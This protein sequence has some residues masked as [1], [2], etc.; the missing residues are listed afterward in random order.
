VSA[1][2]SVLISRQTVAEITT[3]AHAAELWPTFANRVVLLQGLLAQSTGALDRAVECYRSARTLELGDDGK[4]GPVHLLA[5]LAYV[6]ARV[7]Q[8]V[9][10][11]QHDL[12]SL[13]PIDDPQRILASIVTNGDES[14][15][16][17]VMLALAAVDASN[18]SLPAV[19]VIGSILEAVTGSGI[20]KAKC[21]VALGHRHADRR[22]YSL[23]AALNLVTASANAYARCAIL[24]LLGNLFVHV[25]SDQASKMLVNAFDLARLMGAAAPGLPSPELVAPGQ[26]PLPSSVVGH[27]GIGLWCG[28]RLLAV[29]TREG[30][31]VKATA[32]VALNRA[33]EAALATGGNSAA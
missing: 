33:H 19:Q 5:T 1:S 17:L 4:P 26:P 3:R 6:L 7:V 29:Y 13:P 31:T 21:V 11:S 30:D 32:Q 9:R 16:D 24:A 28:E 8:G 25:Q 18:T 27:A 22:R 15:D 10:P 2:E 14:I 12:S 23:S 20:S